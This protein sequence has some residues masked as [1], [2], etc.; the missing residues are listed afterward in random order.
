MENY[1]GEIRLFAGT[2]APEGWLFCQGQ[3]LQI[4]GNEALY[5]LLGTTYGGDGTSTFAL[6]NLQGRTPVG[7]GQRPGL[8]SY[9][10]GQLDGQEAVV[11]TAT[12][13]P[14][15]QHPLQ[16][17]VQAGVG[18]PAQASPAGAYFGDQ[19]GAAYQG[20]ATGSLAPDAVVGQQTGPAGS[21]QPHPNLQPLLALNFIIA[22]QGDYPSPQ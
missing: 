15:H 8:S 11:L 14:T 18:T 17:R 21:S 10:L 20:T 6:P 3:L 7:I 1:V 5:Q 16:V 4:A 13:L 19:A 22:T 9:A 2:Y 12:H